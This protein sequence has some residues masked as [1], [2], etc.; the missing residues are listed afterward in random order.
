MNTYNFTITSSRQ[1]AIPGYDLSVPIDDPSW[2]PNIYN[3]ALPT[4]L[5]AYYPGSGLAASTLS[6]T[7]CGQY[8]LNSIDD[9]NHTAVMNSDL[10]HHFKFTDGVII[11][12]SGNNNHLT[13]TEYDTWSSQF[14]V[15]GNSHYNGEM[16]GGGVVTPMNDGV[17][18]LKLTA[19]TKNSHHYYYAYPGFKSGKRYR[20]TGK[21]MVPQS[22]S[23]S[24]ITQLQMVV[25]EHRLN[26]VTVGSS[27]S[28]WAKVATNVHE[29]HLLKTIDV[30]HDVWIPYDF[31]FTVTDRNATNCALVM[32]ACDG[33]KATNKRT[34]QGAFNKTDIFY[35]AEYTVK[36]VNHGFVKDRHGNDNAALQLGIPKGDSSTVGAGYWTNRNLSYLK[37]PTST[38]LANAAKDQF[39]WAAWINP[40]YAGRDGTNTGSKIIVHHDFS[41]GDD[42]QLP[43]YLTNTNPNVQAERAAAPYGF[44]T[45]YMS[46]ETPF[47]D[48][49]NW[50][51][52]SD[53]ASKAQTGRGNAVIVTT[54]SRSGGGPIYYDL[55]NAAPDFKVGKTYR[56]SQW[57]YGV[58]P[59]SDPEWKP[60][61]LSFQTQHGAGDD[62][63]NLSHEFTPTQHTW[64][65]SLIHI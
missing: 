65:L 13:V 57:I 45:N 1:D 42:N 26:A 10:T 11:D 35:I 63:N 61:R 31:E 6:E 32:Y 52:A 47:N 30:Q 40:D 19:T 20:I 28:K 15:G 27:A 56:V 14:Q 46:T 41:T 23:T 39:T 50:L 48:N 21:F 5:V 4:G 24:N 7:L 53:G 54:K 9:G 25:D 3:Q 37:G 55:N 38:A 49:I 17:Y 2:R 58:D 12:Y 43:G 62:E 59:G 29:E 33:R 8:N 18:A 44:F 34:W 60:I 51:L 64:T 16:I 36:E 22:G